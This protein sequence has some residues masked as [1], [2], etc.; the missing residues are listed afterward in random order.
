MI[1][2]NLLPP[3]DRDRKR[4]FDLPDLSTVYMVGAVLIVIGSVL[5]FSFLQSHRIANLEE[6]IE[7][8]RME[9]KKLAPQLAKIKKITKERGEVNKRL[10]LI[11]SLDKYRFFRV[12]LLNDIS[13]KIPRNCWLTDITE[14]SPGK[15]AIDGIT[16]NN[17][18]V[19]DM[20]TN[21]ETSSLFTKVDLSVVE[22]GTIHKN[23]VMKFSLVGNAIP[24]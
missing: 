17:Y 3:E 22:E 18:K 5:A 9:S 23:K 16:F 24:Q 21:L 20:M 7:T 8:A 13:I 19:A 15:Y 14:L 1:R 10:Q 11:T 12:R 4:S 2:I 6:K